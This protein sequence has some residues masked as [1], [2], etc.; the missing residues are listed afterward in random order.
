MKSTFFKFYLLFT[1]LLLLTASCLDDGQPKD[2]V[3]T[4]TLY[5]SE[6]MSTDAPLF[7]DKLVPCLLV[8][9]KENADWTKLFPGE[10]EGFT[11]E[12]G[13]AYKLSVQKTTLANPPADGSLYKY[14]L[15]KILSKEKK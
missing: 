10:I 3:Q 4:I 9:E 1:S 12:E 8:K 5:V 15:L 6:K 13:Y 2:K 14:K 11:Y 7:S